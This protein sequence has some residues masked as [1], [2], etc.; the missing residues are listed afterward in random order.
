MHYENVDKDYLDYNTTVFRKYAPFYDLA[1]MFLFSVRKQLR[2]ELHDT[3][4]ILDIAC[5]TGTLS[6]ALAKEGYRVTGIDLSLDML[7]R[8]RKKGNSIDKVQFLYQDAS[9]LPFPNASFDATV[10]SF[11]LH[12]MPQEIRGS[13]L[14][15]MKRVTKVGGKI[16]IADYTTDPRRKIVS[17]IEYNFPIV[18]ETK[19]YKSFLDKGL[20]W[21]LKEVGLL[22]IKSK[23]QLFG[24]VQIVVSIKR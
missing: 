11:S 8:A 2:Q 1:E 14:Q 12:D 19:Y 24:F 18:W 9:R 5:G 23:F 22:P 21:Y 3:S 20:A 4:D 17:F 15:E 16:I 10:I 6:V 13:V 7:A